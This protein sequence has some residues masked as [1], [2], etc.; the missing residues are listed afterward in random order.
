[1]HLAGSFIQRDLHCILRYTFLSVYFNE[2]IVLYFSWSTDLS[3]VFLNKTRGR[4]LLR[5]KMFK[6]EKML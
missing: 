4:L 2:M 5:W 6:L 3:L 1:M